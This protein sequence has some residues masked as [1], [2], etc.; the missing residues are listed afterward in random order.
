MLGCVLLGFEDVD[1]LI[2]VSSL[3]SRRGLEVS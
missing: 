1:F 3:T 2:G